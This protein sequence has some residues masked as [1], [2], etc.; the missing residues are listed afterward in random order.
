MEHNKVDIIMEVSLL[1]SHLVFPSK[2]PLEPAVYTITHLWQKYNFWLAYDPAYPE[3]DYSNFEEC[4]WTE[5]Y[6]DAKEAMIAN[7]PEPNGKDVPV[8]GQWTYTRQEALW[9]HDT[10]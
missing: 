6:W 1:L 5:F 9:F 3:I 10:H 8:C 2:G 7:V 4:D